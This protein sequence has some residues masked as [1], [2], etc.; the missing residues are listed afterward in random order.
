MSAEETITKREYQKGW[1]SFDEKEAAEMSS[2]RNQKE[3]KIRDLRYITNEAIFLKYSYDVFSKYFLDK[4][5][6]LAFYN[7]I[8]T[9][10][11][12]NKFL[13]IASF[14]KFL[15]VDG[16]FLNTKDKNYDEYIDYLDLTYK[17]IAIF[18]FIEALYTEDEYKEFYD[19]LMK[20]A[21]Y[22]IDNKKALEGLYTRYKQKYG[23]IKKAIK[24][25][26]SLDDESKKHIQEKFEVYKEGHRQSSTDAD[27]AKLFYTIRN[28]F[29]HNA[30][31][32]VQ[33]NNTQPPIYLN[34]KITN[35]AELAKHGIPPIPTSQTYFSIGNKG[36]LT[37][38][39]FDDI[40]F[41]FERGF[42]I[43]F[44]YDKAMFDGL[45]KSL[46]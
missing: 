6:F 40:K 7:T 26:E 36:I 19:W 44:G 4:D 28:N 18:S 2:S 41:I 37:R 3:V 10:E 21:R 25:F 23:S 13:K 43:Y 16:E 8:N 9:K 38:L 29:I 39:F 14:Y 46:K 22:P 34:N 11:E 15:I 31:L 42:L 24:F 27:L 32:V 33:F 30:D 20:E 5:S 1:D 45:V 17:Y 35:E 12:K